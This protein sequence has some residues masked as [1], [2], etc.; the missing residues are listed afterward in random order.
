MMCT[1]LKLSSK[2]QRR[3]R[4]NEKSEYKNCSKFST[5]ALWTTF[6]LLFLYS[7]DKFN[8]GMFGQTSMALP[9]DSDVYTACKR[10][11]TT[12][13][14]VCVQ[15]SMSAFHYTLSHPENNRDVSA[16]SRQR[17]LSSRAQLV[18]F[19]TRS[20]RNTGIDASRMRLAA[21]IL[22]RAQWRHG[23][24]RDETKYSWV[25]LNLL[26]YTDLRAF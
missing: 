2:W 15:A 6:D 9:P 24:S 25:V 7:K 17:R 20:K 23:C 10:A 3:N 21:C 18:C 5:D 26:A 11:Y 19:L 16:Y 8:E 4:A 14:F 22:R 12:L 13:H 1:S